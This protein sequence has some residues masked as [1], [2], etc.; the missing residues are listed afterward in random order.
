MEGLGGQG[1]SR[2]QREEEDQS[3]VL[4]RVLP[5]REKRE[6]K[7]G[8]ALVDFGLAA[9]AAAAAASGGGGSSSTN[10]HG[11]DGGRR[12][13]GKGGRFIFRERVLAVGGQSGGGGGGR[14]ARDGDGGRDYDRM[15]LRGGIL[16]RG[17]DS[18]GDSR[19]CMPGSRHG[20]GCRTSS[21]YISPSS[22]LQLR[23]PFSAAAGG[24]GGGGG[25]TLDL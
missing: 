21:P 2:N 5:K 19:R 9:A 4:P 22:A 10:S 3:P 8:S 11:D 7:S 14:F 1:A 20:V 23:N 6:R 18:G 25:A 16:S 24:G 12:F 13:G 15:R 17:H